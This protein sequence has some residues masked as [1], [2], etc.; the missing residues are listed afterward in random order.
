MS[1]SPVRV[2]VCGHVNG[3]VSKLLHKVDSLSKKA[4][5]DVLLVTGDLFASTP[6]SLANEDDDDVWMDDLLSGNKY[7]HLPSV[8][9]LGPR[10]EYQ[11]QKYWKMICKTTEER[12]DMES[13]FTNGCDCLEGK[14][15]VLG[16]KGVM[17]CAD[18]LTI[19][20]FCGSESDGFNDG[21]VESITTLRE[22]SGSTVTDILMTPFWP[23]GIS[24]SCSM[25]V[26][27]PVSSRSGMGSLLVS[28]LV[29][30]LK[31]RY[32]LSTS[33]QSRDNPTG[34]FFERQP[35]GN[36]VVLQ[37]QQ[38]AVT[39]FIS[40]A[41]FSS[42]KKDPK[43]LY[44]FNIKPASELLQLDSKTN[45]SDGRKELV[46]QPEDTTESPFLGM[47]LELRTAA[48]AKRAKEDQDAN[49]QFF[50][51]IPEKRQQREQPRGDAMDRGNNGRRYQDHREAEEGQG[52]R[53]S[54]QSSIHRHDQR[55]QIRDR[56][57][58]EHDTD[59]CWFCLASPKVE[60]QHVISIGNHCYLATAKGGL[61]R[62]HLLILPIK[63]VRSSY[64]LEKECQQEMEKMKT[65]LTQ[66]FDTQNKFLVFFERN[67][68][69]SHMQIQVIPIPKDIAASKKEQVD[70]ETQETTDSSTPEVHEVLKTKILRILR[71]EKLNWTDI[72]IELNLSD[73]QTKPGPYFY[74]NIPFL[75]VQLL[76]PIRRED[77][78]GN[79]IFFNLQLGRIICAELLGIN[80]QEVLD[81]KRVTE[82]LT[83]NEEAE[84]AMDFRSRFK[85]F[86]FTLED[87]DE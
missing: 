48:A 51:R 58:P 7:N 35:F 82:S 60:K 46:H 36:H 83:M 57:R 54:G 11:R 78:H 87:D 31:P 1:V 71:A 86:D 25:D 84:R 55:E 49:L 30:S 26:P 64:D 45:T 75:S 81:W 22:A 53:M 34:V 42:D 79:Q 73:A 37:E 59:S 80:C 63:H 8:Y 32:V 85:P 3:N 6:S 61:V 43:W 20:Y 4:N 21:D 70:P 65:A 38:K 23:K 12:P 39:R 74:I 72:P 66:Y 13:C 2:A 68:K 16:R 28:K 14:V 5:F 24:A 10:T 47:R 9:V 76:C 44:A 56:R 18:G 40:V 52:D 27:Q 77:K 15:T 41:S 19:A 50:Y 69:S 67:F 17:T 62:D 29:N 33:T